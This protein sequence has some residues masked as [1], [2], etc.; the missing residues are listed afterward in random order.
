M[1]TEQATVITNQIMGFMNN[2]EVKN[3]RAR[4]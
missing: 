2:T 4:K 3:M 1:T